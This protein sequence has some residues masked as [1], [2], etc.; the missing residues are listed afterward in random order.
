[1]THGNFD[2]LRMLRAVPQLKP[3]E[4]RR[5]RDPDT[6]PLAAAIRPVGSLS[7]R[8]SR[9]ETQWP[10]L[11]DKELEHSLVGDLEGRTILRPGLAVIVN[12][13]CGDV[14]VTQPLLHL[15]DVRLMVERVGRGGRPQ[16]V[17]PDGETQRR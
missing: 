7:R 5:R 11:T 1:M 10:V 14:G 3:R 12:S 4:S 9:V 6:L 13:G 2:A 8:K 15:G 16:R 17:R